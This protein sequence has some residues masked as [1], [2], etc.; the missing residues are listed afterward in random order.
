[1]NANMHANRIDM[2][3]YVFCNELGSEAGKMAQWIKHLLHECEGL[4]SNP[5]TQ[6]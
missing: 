2:L 5:K 6:L 3:A 4:S 1:M